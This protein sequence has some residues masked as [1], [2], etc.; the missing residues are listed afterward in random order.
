MP[1]WLRYVILIS[2][3]LFSASHAQQIEE[4]WTLGPHLIISIPQSDFANLSKTG[5]GIGG[6]L[7]YHFPSLPFLRPRL[8]LTYLSYGEKRKSETFSAGYFLVTTRNESF[9]LTAGPQFSIQSGAFTPYLA[10]MGGVYNYRTVTSVPEL[11]Y[12]Y[13]Y[14]VSETS[15][16]LTRLGWNVNIGLLIDIGLGPYIDIGVKYQKIDNAVESKMDERVIKSDAED[17]NVCIGVLFFLK[18]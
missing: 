16:N 15:S 11:Y 4:K 13:G 6:K 10:I 3:L 7:L 18:D 12:S 8:D 1:G 17:I 9:Q 14:P 2:L 5:E